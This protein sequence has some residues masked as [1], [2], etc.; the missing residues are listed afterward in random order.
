[1]NATE[2]KMIISNPQYTGT[3]L[4][5]YLRNVT[6]IKVCAWLGGVAIYWSVERIRYVSQ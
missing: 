3:D 5:E 2:Y 4:R 6:W 1:L